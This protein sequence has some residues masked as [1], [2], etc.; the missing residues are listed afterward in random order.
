MA[1]L[2]AAELRGGLPHVLTSPGG[3]P[4]QGPAAF[5]SV[6]TTFRE[7]LGDLRITVERTVV[8]GGTCAAFCRVTGTPATRSA[9]HR[10]ASPWTSPVSPS[11]GSR[12]VRS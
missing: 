8:Q 4:L 2:T 3:P 5:R 10:P 6:F 9:A 12:T 11:R 7:A 1:H